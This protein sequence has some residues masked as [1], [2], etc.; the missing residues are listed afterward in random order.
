LGFLVAVDVGPRTNELA[1]LLAEA[2]ARCATNTAL[3]TGTVTN[4]HLA[5]LQVQVPAARLQK[6]LDDAFPP[7]DPSAPRPAA[8]EPPVE[9]LQ[10]MAGSWFVATSVPRMLEGVLTRL[11]GAAPAF[12]QFPAFAQGPGST[13][14]LLHAGLRFPAALARLTNAPAPAPALALPGIGPSPARLAT[15]LGLGQLQAIAFD[16]RSEP[17]GWFTEF[18]LALAPGERKGL[19]RTFQPIATNAA[20]PSWVPADTLYFARLRLPGAPAWTAL[21]KVLKDIDPALLGVIQLFTEYAGRTEDVDFNFDKGLIARLGD[22]WIAVS[23]HVASTNEFGADLL[24]HGSPQAADIHHALTLIASPTYLSTFLPPGAPAPRRTVRTVAGSQVVAVELPPLPWQTG[25]ARLLHLGSRDQWVGMAGMGSTIDRFL[26]TTNTPAPLAQSPEFLHALAR[27]GGPDGG[28]VAY[29]HERQSARHA[30]DLMKRGGE[31]LEDLF[32]WAAFSELATR[33]V[34]AAVSWIDLTQ[35]PA[36]DPVARH[37]RYRV[38]AGR[39]R[40]E[41]W[42]LTTFRPPPAQ[43]PPPLPVPPTQPPAK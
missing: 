15:A 5:C 27:V 39:N 25:P 29:S 16:L 42:V 34:T 28:W 6:V 31:P 22:D 2:R 13:N 7:L 4:A 30:F 24:V 26:S 14:T 36:F 32:R 41:G 9:I 3:V 20:P 1:A 18:R 19:F 38:E 40:P 35:W 21:Q 17:D 8:A 12:V 11:G 43:A 37:F 33:A 10:V 23:R